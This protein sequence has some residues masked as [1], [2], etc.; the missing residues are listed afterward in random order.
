MTAP[1]SAETLLAARYQSDFS[2]P[3]GPWNDVIANLLN[4]RSV[5]A[6]K[7]DPLPAGTLERLIAAAQSASTSSNLQAWSVVAVED[8]AKKEVLFE[9][10]GGQRH[11]RQA[12]VF[13]AWLADLHR[14]EVVAAYRN[15]EPQALNYLEML[16]VGVIDAALAAQ[17][18][19]VAAESLGLG[20][21]FVGA[22]RNRI[23]VVAE[24]LDLPAHVMPV[25]G[26]CVGYPDPERPG[27]IRPRMEPQAVMHR[28]SYHAAAQ[29]PTIRRYDDIMS[30]WY[31]EQRI[32]APESWTGHSA[33]R[34]ENAAALSGRDRLHEQ[35][36]ELGFGLR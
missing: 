18:F 19:A 36:L 20:T 10:T 29:L 25:F 8:A 34:I 24:L 1:L 32:K 3:Q 11:V 31:A 7:P 9:V 4:H 15:V 6:Y 13:L 22:L 28:E 23:D 5:R 33:Q 16:L 21:V 30:R 35:L 26:M 14:L 17:N 27:A 12:P 2:L